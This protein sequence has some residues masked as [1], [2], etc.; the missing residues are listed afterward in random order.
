[1]GEAFT[2]NVLIGLDDAEVEVDT[3]LSIF[4]RLSQLDAMKMTDYC[5]LQWSLHA[6][7]QFRPGTEKDQLHFIHHFLMYSLS[8]TDSIICFLCNSFA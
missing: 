4:Q 7:R 1:M 6:S 3:L 5:L 8:H 2:R